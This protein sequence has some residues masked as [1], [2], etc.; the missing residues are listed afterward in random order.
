[1]G[2]GAGVTRGMAGVGG[3]GAEAGEAGPHLRVLPEYGGPTLG[4]SRVYSHGELS[5]TLIGIA[6]SL[7]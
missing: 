5:I 6:C 4:Y 1:M 7:H 3:P 2:K